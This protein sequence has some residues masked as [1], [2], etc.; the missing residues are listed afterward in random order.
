M[1]NWCS[2]VLKL[3][4]P[5]PTMIDRAIKSFEEGKLL[6]E[7]VP[8]PEELLNPET[9]TWSHGPEQAARDKLKEELAEEYGYSSWYDWCIAHWGTKWDV[10]S[11]YPP[12][13]HDATNATFTFESAWAP[14][15]DAYTVMEELG[16]NVEAY[17]YEPGMCFCG[18]YE[19]GCD[20]YVEIEESTY[21]WASKNIPRAIDEMFDISNE[22]AQYEAE[23]EEDENA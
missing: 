7:F 20:G 18:I 4:H 8:C 1:P 10:G 16:F 14:P 12:E 15:V 3:S 19:D 6:Q 2:N 17:Y 23:N 9:T 13:R 11:E 5:D 22:Y 21:D